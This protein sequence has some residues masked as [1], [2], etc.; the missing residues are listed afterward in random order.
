MHW[1]QISN[2]WNSGKDENFGGD[3][4]LIKS[5]GLSFNMLDKIVKS[6][7]VPY[8]ESLTVSSEVWARGIRK[9]VEL[10]FNGSKIKLQ[11]SG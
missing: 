8:L 7:E 3:H 2:F 9:V 6:F 1:K 10:D 11:S 4:S 5:P